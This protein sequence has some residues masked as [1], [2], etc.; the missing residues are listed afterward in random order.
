MK[1]IR[2]IVIQRLG[3]SFRDCTEIVT[4]QLSVPVEGELLVRN[5]FAGINGVYDQMMCLDRVD[6]T[7]VIPPADMGVEA[8]GIVDSCGPGVTDVKPGD[9]VATMTVGTAY[10]DWQ[11]CDATAAIA[12][13][14]ASPEVLA[15]IPSGVSALVALEQVAR[16]GTNE[17]VCITAASGGLGNILTQLAVNAGNHV[18]AICGSDNKAHRLRELGVAR[19]IQYRDE[20]VAEVLATEYRDKL[21]LVL[22]SVGG[23]LFDALVENLAPLGRLVVCGFTSDRV[24]TEQVAQ[25]R[26]YTKLYWKAASIRGFMNYRFAQFAPEARE[27]LLAMLAAD[28]IRP[29]LDDVSFRGLESVADAVEHLLAGHNSG[30]VVVD[31]R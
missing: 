25:E 15:L 8:V 24:P 30:K 16:M 2:K 21:D 14:A 5:H 1:E 18:I 29:L 11:I 31:L 9:A 12:V 4:E 23:E 7:K 17:V 22:D 13:P 28:E 6:H 19:V 26:I 3:A 27:R 10:R 20:D